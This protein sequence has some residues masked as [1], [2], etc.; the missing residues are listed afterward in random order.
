MQGETQNLLY[1]AYGEHMNE[2]EMLR[3][4]PHARC[5]GI[6]RLDGY[7]LCFIG[8]DG[9]ARAALEPHPSKSIPGRVW[10]LYM[11]DESALD[12]VA[13]DSHHTRREVRTVSIGG[14][15]LPVMLY[16]S[17]PGQPHGR[18]GFLTYDIMREA[19]ESAGEDTGTLRRL[20]MQSAP[21]V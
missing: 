18:P 11:S 4:F 12:R 14:M 6:S 7:R 16:I 1:F 17:A 2:Q 19:Y 21:S 13:K 3:E 20:A 9:A 10:S 15:S 5:V 8:Q